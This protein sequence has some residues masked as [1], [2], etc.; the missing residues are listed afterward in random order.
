[1]LNRN[2]MKGLVVEALKSLGGRGSI[3]EVA[4]VIWEKHEADLRTS[5]DF[6]YKWQYDM[7]W[8][9]GNLRES[10]IMKEVSDS[11]KRIWELV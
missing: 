9:A 7:R 11:P 5:G 2:S 8:A 3:V 10:G 1:M 4:R 6:F